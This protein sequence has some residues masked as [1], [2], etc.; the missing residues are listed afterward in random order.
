VVV[1]RFHGDDNVIPCFSSNSGIDETLLSVTCEPAAARHSLWITDISWTKPAV[2]HH[3][4]QL[5]KRGVAIYWID[6]H[7][8]AIERYRSGEIGAACDERVLDESYSAARLT[9]DFLSRHQPRPDLAAE[10]RLLVD[11][12]DDND[13]W[14]HRIPGSRELAQA[15]SVLR[16]REAFEELL[17]IGPEVRLTPLLQD[18]LRRVQI[19]LRRSLA[20]ASASRTEHSLPGGTTLV[21]AVCDGYTSDIAD[22][23]N[24]GARQTVFAFYDLRSAGLSL[25]RSP[26]CNVDLSTVARRLGGGGH[27]AAAGCELPEARVRLAKVV[28]TLVSPAIHDTTG[29]SS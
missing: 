24:E 16:D 2:D 19:E 15:V 1:A 18:A 5:Q 8:T 29:R 3:L 22:L 9:F 13:R 25:R 26:D 21:A 20:L 23:W 6:H 11:M 12:A 14:L 28:A 4:A 10:L 7:R 27:P 17:H